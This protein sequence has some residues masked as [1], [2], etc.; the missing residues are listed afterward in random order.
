M[1]RARTLPREE[2]VS[3]VTQQT[4]DETVSVR[5]TGRTVGAAVLVVVGIICII[6]AI[7]YFTTKA[8]SLPSILGAIKY[9]GHNYT[10]SHSTRSVR[11]IVTIIVGVICLVGA[12]FSFAW[13]TKERV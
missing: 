12:W 10:R 13:K 5:S 7:L 9:N 4:A 11:G 1:K 8:D 3:T 6:A 2:P